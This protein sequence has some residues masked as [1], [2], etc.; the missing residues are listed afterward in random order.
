MIFIFSITI[1]MDNLEQNKKS[2]IGY[3]HGAFNNFFR[4]TA[5][6]HYF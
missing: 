3:I 4:V 2:T 1:V 5:D 6:Y